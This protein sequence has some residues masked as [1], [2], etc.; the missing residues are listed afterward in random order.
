MAKFRNVMVSYV[1]IVLFLNAAIQH[2][3]ILYNT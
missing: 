2:I 3:Q 1:Y